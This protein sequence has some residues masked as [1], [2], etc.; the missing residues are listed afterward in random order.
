MKHNPFLILRLRAALPLLAAV[1]FSPGAAG[2]GHGRLPLFFVPARERPGE[3]AG[4]SL[5]Q[6]GLTA[7]FT[8]QQVSF[9]LGRQA[10][11]MRFCGARSRPLLEGRQR[12][13]GVVN[14]FLGDSPE[15]WRTDVPTYASIAYRDLYPGI[16]LIYDVTGGEIKSEFR[17]GPG[18]A[19]DGIRWRYQGAAA[20]KLAAD[21]SLLVTTAAGE[22]REHKPVVYQPASGGRTAVEG[23]FRIFEDGSVGFRVG[24]YDRGRELVIDPVLS[25]STY[26][27]GSGMDAVRAIAV[28]SAGNAYVAGY[29]DSS[30]FPVAG[31]YQSSRKGGVDAFVAKLNA[32]GTALVYCTYLGGSYDDRAFGIA[33]DSSGSAYLTGWTYSSN[34]PT[35]SGARQRALAGGRDAFVTKLSA[36]GNALSYSTFLGGSS[37]DS[38]NA[39]AIDSTGNAYVAGDTSSTNFPVLNGYRGSNAGRQD[40]FISKLNPTGL[41]LVWSTYLGGSGD[42]SAA[43]LALDAS[44]NVYIAGGTTSADFPTHLALQSASGGGQDAFV[45]RLYPDGRDLAFS[46]YL[47]GSG[48]TTGAGEMATA[49]GVDAGGYI[50]VAGYTSSTNFPVLNAR[51]PAHGGGTLDGFLAK[52]NPGASLAFSTYFGGAGADYIQ[53]LAL[54]PSG[55]VVLT[56]YTASSNLPVVSAVQPTKAGGYDAFVVRF[57][58]AGDS[59]DLCSYLG[60]TDSDAAYAVAADAY[61]ALWIA[62]QTLSGGF[63]VKNAIQA[64]NAGGYSGFVAKIGTS[65]PAAV[66]RS[67]NGN[68]LLTIYGSLGLANAYGYITSAPGISQ[69]STGDTF[70]VGRND[71]TCVYMNIFRGD[72]QTW[73]GGW[74]RAGCSMYGDPAVAAAPS[75]EAFVVARD[76]SYA[77]WINRYTPGAGFGGWIPLGGSFASEPVMA[78]APDGA[79]YVLGRDASGAVSSGRY[80]TSSGFLGWYQAPTSTLAA[81]KPALTVGS[82]GAVYVAI[83]ASSNNSIW[84]ARLQGDAW[85]PWI[86]GGGQAKT[87]P[88][89][90]AAGGYIY[91]AVTNIYDQVYVQGFRE[92]TGNGWQGS[93]QCL[94]GVLTKA[95]IA[96]AGGSWY[97]AGKNNAG[98]LYWYK[99]GVGWSYLGYTGLPSSE[100]AAS[101]K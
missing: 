10:L 86:S 9:E 18:A 69:N 55:A 26:L 56:G 21:G 25:Y 62:G 15:G 31:A 68:T 64:T 78:R 72:T 43:A 100:V 52:L 5:R 90:A 82:D 88:E 46:T 91:A 24:A 60:G 81:G 51:Q 80:L 45:A 30:D 2:S 4:Y 41:S 27:G 8:P 61:G 33:V 79:I 6:G 54:A 87:D 101:P 75:G 12:Q 48:G 76:A 44:G 39:I 11:R 67:T 19:A 32:A 89:V 49:I 23:G 34:F 83:R 92:G 17:V 58:A 50:Y 96:S 20:V 70:V 29:T 97:I 99:P 71:T 98:T 47:G 94:N 37:H 3:A 85:G 22:L 13:P 59:V 57:S 35:T 66:F 42:E 93:W 63:P 14:Y 84:M 40:A 36:A 28:D 38:G 16:D 7:H 65:P 77:Y 74:I 1:A 73:Q 53:G 95:S